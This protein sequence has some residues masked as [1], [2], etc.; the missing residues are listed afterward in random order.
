MIRSAR[1]EVPQQL[2][3]LGVVG[4]EVGGDVHRRLSR[5]DAVARRHAQP[6]R[7]RPPHVEGPLPVARIVEHDPDRGAGADDRRIA[8]EDP[9]LD[10]EL[11]SVDS[12]ARPITPPARWS[13]A[14]G[15]RSLPNWSTNAWPR[16][17]VAGLDGGE[18]DA[19]PGAAAPPLLGGAALGVRTRDLEAQ[20][21][22]R[23]VTGSRR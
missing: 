6:G 23:M 18:R 4:L 20:P 5:A 7:E 13:M 14:S 3:D 21:S 15:P 12:R 22:W 9:D 16:R 1:P 2:E 19:P 11:E 10:P 17:I 8:V